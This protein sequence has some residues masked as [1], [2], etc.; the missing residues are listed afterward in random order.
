MRYHFYLYGGLWNRLWDVPAPKSLKTT[1]QMNTS[2]DKSASSWQ[3]LWV[4]SLGQVVHEKVMDSG[5]VEETNDILG[6]N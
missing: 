3:Q 2:F 1:G 5:S 6:K 4:Q